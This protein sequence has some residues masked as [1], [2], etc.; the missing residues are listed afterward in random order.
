MSPYQK[1]DLDALLEVKQSTGRP[2][3]IPV[4]AV[5]SVEQR[6]TQ[7]NGFK[8]YT[9]VQQWLQETL[10]IEAEYCTVYELVRYRLKAKLKA[11]R[12]VHKKQGSVALEQLKKTWMT[13]HRLWH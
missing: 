12:P 2:R 9:Q 1:Q 11:A 7:I 6:L 8:S 13:N 3:V 4:W 5:V 10:G